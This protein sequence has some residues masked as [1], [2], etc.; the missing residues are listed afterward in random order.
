MRSCAIMLFVFFALPTLSATCAYMAT[1]SKLCAVLTGLHALVVAGL[2]YAATWSAMAAAVWAE[3][4]R[5]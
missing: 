1:S 4:P 3:D 2:T 5:K